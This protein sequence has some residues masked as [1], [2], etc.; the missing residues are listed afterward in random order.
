MRV[1]L[2]GQ[3][4]VALIPGELGEILALKQARISG[5]DEVLPARVGD[6]GSFELKQFVPE[7]KT[8]SH[9]GS[10]DL[11][12]RLQEISIPSDSPLS[13][14]VGVAYA[15]NSRGLFFEA[16]GCKTST[17]RF[18]EVIPIG[19]AIHD[20]KKA[21]YAI[22]PVRATGKDLA[23]E[24]FPADSERQLTV[25]RDMQVSEVSFEDAGHSSIL[26]D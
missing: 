7:S 5:A 8:A 15:A 12:V 14:T 19:N 13:I 10:E 25:F 21:R 22:S 26:G 17:A 18:G 24:L 6:S 1:T 9:Q 20:A 3:P 2:K 16:S 23:L 11:T 4:A